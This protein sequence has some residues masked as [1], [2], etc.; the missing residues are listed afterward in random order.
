MTVAVESLHNAEEA[1]PTPAPRRKKRMVRLMPPPLAAGQP[2]LLD[3]AL[4]VAAAADQRVAELETRL[5]YLEGQVVTDEVSGVFNRRGFVLEFSRAIATARRGGPAGAVIICDLDGFKRIN[6][7]LGHATG[8]EVLRQVSALLRHKVRK[9]DSV[10]RLGGDEFAVL[11]IGATPASAQ[12]KCQYIARALAAIPQQLSGQTIP[13][14]ASFGIACFSGEDE[15]E[16]VLHRA[17][18]AMYEEK[19]RKAGPERNADRA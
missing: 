17:D 2:A 1:A 9:M 6:D 12:R 8:D 18:M 13:L 10:G 7:L 3:W 14:S 15:E 5:A 19:R 11:L 16:T 4:A